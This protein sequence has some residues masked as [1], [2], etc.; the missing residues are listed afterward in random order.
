VEDA[1]PAQ[2]AETSS[3]TRYSRGRFLGA[4]AG[5]IA[6]L[7]GCYVPA[8]RGA[9][10]RALESLAAH[11]GAEVT[12]SDTT[13]TPVESSGAALGIALPNDTYDTT[14]LPAY[15]ALTGHHPPAMI[16][17]V[18]W[19]GDSYGS[20]LFPSYA[21]EYV[22]PSTVAPIIT[23]LPWDF[24]A[25]PTQPLYTLD[26]I[27]SGSHDAYIETWATACKQWGQPLVI[28]FMHEMNGNWYPWAVNT[29]EQN[30]TWRKSIAAW[31]YVWNTFQVVGAS[32]ARW[33]WCP[34]RVYP[35]SVATD[36][37]SGYPGD[38]YVDMLGLD[39]YNYGTTRFGVGTFDSAETVFSPDL[40]R[41]QALSV[42]S[43]YVFETGCVED[44]GDKAAWIT[45]T[46]GRYFETRP[47]VDGVFWFQE[48]KSD[49]GEVDY[50]VNSS[51]ASLA[52]WIESAV[53]NP[54]W[55]VQFDPDTEIATVPQAL[56]APEG[57]ASA[58][59]ASAQTA[60]GGNTEAVR[61]ATSGSNAAA[62]PDEA[63]QALGAADANPKPNATTPILRS[64]RI[65]RG[66]RGQRVLR[67]DF[68]IRQ[69]LR[70][71]V[72]LRGER[73]TIRRCQATIRP[74]K[75]IELSLPEGLDGGL[76]NFEIRQRSNKRLIVSKT[77]R[78]IS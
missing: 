50:R 18:A 31:Q 63:P 14:V 46:F 54:Y 29:P 71:T 21:L 17:Y 25:G 24:T 68:L 11:E 9:P 26:S 58:T 3:P 43:T 27:L 56:A 34:N 8:G 75:A 40:D 48:D 6:G 32:N 20:E 62:S 72:V 70:V 12:L 47:E 39:A 76:M 55:S 45:E 49:Q 36:F 69:P 51:A 57:V 2:Q 33:A 30:N 13:A 10:A 78:K 37:S 65:E 61:Q 15:E 1:Q 52:A 53:N 60:S 59:L 66:A 67:L 73:H 28:R 64:A 5:T 23:W 41:L 44:G 38:T 22:Y 19:A 35:G 77:L 42:K 7:A 16:C 4:T 74:G